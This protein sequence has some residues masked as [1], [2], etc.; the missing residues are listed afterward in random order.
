MQKQKTPI[1]LGIVGLKYI[2][3]PITRL[4]I[5]ANISIDDIIL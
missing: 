1:E 4:K 3:D 2:T 5:G